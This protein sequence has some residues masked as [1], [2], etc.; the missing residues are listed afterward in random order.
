MSIKN[1]V[2]AFAIHRAPAYLEKDPETNHAQAD[3]H[4]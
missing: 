1:S 2:S 4:D 3:G